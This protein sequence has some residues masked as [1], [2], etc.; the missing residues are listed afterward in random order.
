MASKDDI[1]HKYVA[2]GTK[3]EAEPKKQKMISD[4]NGY[5]DDD[6]DDNG[7]DDDHSSSSTDNDYSL[8][9]EEEVSLEAETNL[10]T[11][12]EEELLIWRGRSDDGDTSDD[13]EESQYFSND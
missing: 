6:D 5:D 3:E 9:L 4:D 7:N 8:E 13:E 12:S 10:P 1:K 11:G 2:D